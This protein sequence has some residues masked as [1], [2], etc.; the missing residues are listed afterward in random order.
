MTNT[1]YCYSY[2]RGL[3]DLPEFRAWARE[4]LGSCD[5]KDMKISVDSASG[6]VRVGPYE[7][8]ISAAGSGTVEVTDTR[9]G[10]TI[11]SWGDPHFTTGD[12]D[13]AQ[14]HDGALTLDLPEGLKITLTPTDLNSAPGGVEFIQSVSIMTP[15]EAIVVENVYQ[16]PEFGE[17]QRGCSGQIDA[18]HDDGTVLY[19]PEGGELDDLY[20]AANGSQLLGNDPSQRF[21]EHQLD[22]IGGESRYDFEALEKEWMSAW[23]KELELDSSEFA[24]MDIFTILFMLTGKVQDDAR[25]NV[26][27]L[28]QLQKLKSQHDVA[29]SEVESG[30]NPNALADF[31]QKVAAFL[32]LDTT[33]GASEGE[34][35]EGGWRGQVDEFLSELAG[36]ITVATSRVQQME[37]YRQ[38]LN[39][40]VSQL[41]SGDHNAKMQILRNLPGN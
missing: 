2:A 16:A 27:H 37:Q 24:G 25:K 34:G 3:E 36:N 15:L 41:L 18:M 12:G 40:M 1:D 21:G 30:A 35:A 7:I 26:E 28:A 4:T 6:L 9:T 29:L 13:H 14:F 5:T 22:G 11:R 39:T 38:Q 32:G 8:S 19:V 23:G 17:V 31:E 10:K 20:F 33:S